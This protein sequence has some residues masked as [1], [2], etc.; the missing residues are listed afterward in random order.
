MNKSS[1]KQHINT[2][3][4][5]L[6]M[7]KLRK[8][9]GYFATSIAVFALAGCSPSGNTNTST[10]VKTTK[11]VPTTQSKP[12]ENSASDAIKTAAAD[13]VDPFARGEKLYKRCKTCHTLSQG[14][15]HKIGPNLWAVNGSVAGTREDF[16]YS[17]AMKSS[18][19]QWT[20]ETLNEFLKKPSRYM[21][22]NR[23]SFVGLKR[24]EDRDALIK[25]LNKATTPQP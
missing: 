7:G 20:D 17:E 3:T 19:L 1:D 14:G 10:T 25:Y 9:Q 24:P 6:N 13:T 11:S 2:V 4:K 15:R 23:M 8:I 5:G 16:A 21:P 22:K 18:G 12:I